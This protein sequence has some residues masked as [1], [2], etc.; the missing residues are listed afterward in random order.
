MQPLAWQ[1]ARREIEIKAQNA[2][3][4]LG[5]LLGVLGFTIYFVGDWGFNYSQ[6]AKF[7]CRTYCNIFWITSGTSK[8]VTEC[9]S[10]DPLFITNMLQNI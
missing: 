8:N 10:M 1:Q 9:G 2:E 3:I 5:D 6:M 7:D 4:V